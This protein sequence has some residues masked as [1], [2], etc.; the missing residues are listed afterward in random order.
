MAPVME[1]KKKQR[2]LVPNLTLAAARQV[3]MAPVMEER[4][5]RGCQIP[6]PVLAAIEQVS[7]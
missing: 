4:K 7:F 3:W 2:H 5:K 6:I 1:K